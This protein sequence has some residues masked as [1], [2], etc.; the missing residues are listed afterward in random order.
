MTPRIGL[1]IEPEDDAGGKCCLNCLYF[2]EEGGHFCGYVMDD[3]GEEQWEE[4]KAAESHRCIYWE[5]T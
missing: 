4:V 1:Q 2:R 5:E 3:Y